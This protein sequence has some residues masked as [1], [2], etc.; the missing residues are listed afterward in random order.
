MK[1]L[2]ITLSIILAVIVSLVVLAILINFYFT[3]EWIPVN[4]GATVVPAPET[5]PSNYCQNGN[6]KG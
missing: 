5:F 2:L 3:V 1:K 4:N 6:C